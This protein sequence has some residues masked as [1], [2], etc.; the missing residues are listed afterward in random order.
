MREKVL[1]NDLVR[2]RS[3]TT[4]VTIALRTDLSADEQF[5]WECGEHVEP[6]AKSSHVDQRVVLGA[7]ISESCGMISSD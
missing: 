4:I 2:L 3:P 6:K 7:N 5:E 1:F